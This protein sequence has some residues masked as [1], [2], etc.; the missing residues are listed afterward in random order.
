MPLAAYNVSGEYAMLKAAAAA[1]MID[2]DAGDA[3]G[4][5][6]DPPRRRRRDPH[7]PRARSRA[8]C[9]VRRRPAALACVGFGTTALAI[10]LA[11]GGPTTTGC[12]THQCDPSTYDYVDGFM[13]DSTIF[14]TTAMNQPMDPVQRPDHGPD[15]VPQGGPRLELGDP[16]S[17]GRDRIRRRTPPKHSTTATSR[18]HA[19]GQLAEIQPADDGAPDG[20]RRRPLLCG[21]RQGVRRIPRADERLVRPVLR[22]R[23][24][25]VHPSA[26][27]HG[28][29][30]R[31]RGGQSGSGRRCGHGRRAAEAG[32][33]DAGSD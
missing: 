33:A 21:Q 20:R 18:R 28:A 14:V 32:A 12:T 23:A 9:S 5:H 11:T 16:A 31:S 3:G 24:G 26:G 15:L 6:V 1:G 7:L 10:V 25:R 8:R 30:G 27:G 29:R 13:E 22:V 4:P 17:A 19:A 2:Y